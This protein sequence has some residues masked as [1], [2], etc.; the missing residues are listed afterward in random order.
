MATSTEFGVGLVTRFLQQ[1][2]VTHE[3]VEHSPT[4]CACDEAAAAHADERYTAKT[5]VLHDRDGVSVAVVPAD[6]RLD[7]E[8]T[9]RLLGGTR[10]MRLATEEEIRERFP[11]FDI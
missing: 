1:A 8:K 10:H 3:V 6:H 4:Y 11:D 7:L 2:G 5:L 9:R